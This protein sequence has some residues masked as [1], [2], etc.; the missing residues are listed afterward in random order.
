MTPSRFAAL[1]EES[2]MFS[3]SLRARPGPEWSAMH[4]RRVGEQTY[5]R[6]ISFLESENWATQIDASKLRFPSS[7]REPAFRT[8]LRIE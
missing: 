4:H 8:S 3:E 1:L 7:T 6:D 5:D 2:S